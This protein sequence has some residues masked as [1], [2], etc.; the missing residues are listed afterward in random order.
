MART[1]LLRWSHAA[2]ALLSHPWVVVGVLVCLALV[3]V[4]DNLGASP[5]TVYDEA[6][7]TQAALNVINHGLLTWRGDPVFIHPPLFFLLEGA[8]LGLTGAATGGFFEATRAARTLIGL[9]VALNVGLVTALAWQL[10]GTARPARRALIAGAAGL[11]AAFDPVLLRYGRVGMI[12]TLALTAGLIVLLLAW[13]RRHAGWLAWLGILGPAIGVALLTKEI[14]IFLV[15]VPLLAFLLERRLA[16]AA[17]ATAALVVGIGLWGT[18]PAW[19]TSLGLEGRFVEQKLLTFER[20]IGVLQITG[21]NR[22]NVSFLQA[23]YVSAPQYIASYLVLAIGAV[24]L[25]WLWLRGTSESGTFLVAW[26]GSTYLFGAFTIVRGQLNEQFFTYLMPGA[27]VAAIF[28][29]D[30]IIA[31]ARDRLAGS[32]ALGRL[33]TAAPVLG[34]SLLLSLG[35]ASWWRFHHEARDDGIRSMAEYVS[36][37]LPACAAVNASGDV[38]KYVYSLGPN[39]VSS[40]ASGPRAASR[41]VR[42]FFLNPKDVFAR[43]G[44]MSPDLAGW[45]QAN[46]RLVQKYPS[47]TYWAVQLWRTDYGP[48]DPIGDQQPIDRGVFVNV[49]DSACGGFAVVDGQSGA[50]FGAYRR[51]GGKPVLGRPASRVWAGPSGTRQAFDTLVLQAANGPTGPGEAKPGHVVQEIAAR[52]PAALDA[53]GLPRP[54]LHP[55]GRW[56]IVRP[57]L[58]DPAI[59]RA[60]LGRDLRTASVADW[61]E[62]RKVWGD[63]LGPPR[64][65]PDGVVRQA[66]QAAVW[67]SPGGAAPARLAMLGGAIA[68][69]GIIPQAAR[70]PE[71]VPGIGEPIQAVLPSAVEPFVTLFTAVLLGWLTLLGGLAVA[72]RYRRASA[73]LRAVVAGRSAPAGESER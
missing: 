28:A 63:P 29:A 69:A 49:V 36:T 7:Y 31:W 33:L 44:R 12:D 58:L 1:H 61:L 51:L 2:L 59:T 17:R 47:I 72:R 35:A 34:L 25:A 66:F 6:V 26:L 64:R 55:R 54:E 14:S 5:D 40:F 8:W 73:S 71:P 18:F 43:Y 62:A 41:G 11:L 52:Q 15:V 67:E 70:A 3:I 27:V 22:P 4:L 23:L 10:A 39:P 19:A 68:D 56:R 45:I 32:P 38:Q 42:Y 37:E 65:M 57:L 20:L 9:S 30:A 21:W 53:H 60:Y 48:F 46:G 24:V 50:F 16:A 13:H